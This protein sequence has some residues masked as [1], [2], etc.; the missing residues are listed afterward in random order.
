MMPGPGQPMYNAVKCGFD[1]ID[2]ELLQ[3]SLS[4]IND[5]LDCSAQNRN[6]FVSLTLHT[7]VYSLR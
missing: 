2:M 4:L 3:R 5:N 1:N 7:K 6:D